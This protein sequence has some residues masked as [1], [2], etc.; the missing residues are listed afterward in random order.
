MARV[1]LRCSVVDFRRSLAHGD[2]LRLQILQRRAQLGLQWHLKYPSTRERLSK[3][4]LDQCVES[5]LPHSIVAGGGQRVFEV[6]CLYL[7]SESV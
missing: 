4:V 1:I 3:L 2:F 6:Y 7:Y 5:P